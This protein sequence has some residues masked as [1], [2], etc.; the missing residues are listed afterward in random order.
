MTI[1]EKRNCIDTCITTYY[2]QLVLQAN[3]KLLH[4]YRTDSSDGM[5]LV[6]EVLCSFYEKLR[7]AQNVCRFHQLFLDNKLHLY[8]FKCINT[9]ARSASAPFIQS[10][11]KSR[12]DLEYKDNI[13]L[14][15]EDVILEKEQEEIEE[16]EILIRIKTILNRKEARQL[17]GDKYKYYTELFKLY[18]IEGYTIKEIA[19]RFSASYPTVQKHLLFV[20]RKIKKLL[21]N[22]GYALNRTNKI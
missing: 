19:E 17:F 15:E 1:A 2:D 22:E 5:L 13:Y 3:Y 18:A 20:R 10:K 6:S 8:L 7:N 11:I 12:K 16:D 21:T 14:H 9:N 4:R